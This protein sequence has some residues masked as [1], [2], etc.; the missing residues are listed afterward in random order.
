MQAQC[1][2][3]MVVLA[4][5]VLTVQVIH[6][7]QLVAV[8][9]AV[10]DRE[11]LLMEALEAVVHRFLPSVVAALVVPVRIIQV[12]A[13]L[14]VPVQAIQVAMELATKTKAM[15]KNL[16]N[17]DLVRQSLSNEFSNIIFRQYC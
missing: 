2:S 7:I 16:V 12:A 5:L 4:A 14:A 9:E 17:I 3:M 13:A 10:L 1:H 8:L 15:V 6:H 11:I